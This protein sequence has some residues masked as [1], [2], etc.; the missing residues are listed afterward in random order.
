MCT[1]PQL[2]VKAMK[3]Y[4]QPYSYQKGPCMQCEIHKRQ[5]SCPLPKPAKHRMIE[6]QP[7]RPQL[8]YMVAVKYVSFAKYAKKM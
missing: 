3:R 2:P 1:S 7:K 6:H 8:W 4:A 5:I